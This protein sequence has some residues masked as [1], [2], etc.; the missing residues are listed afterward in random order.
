MH[1]SDCIERPSLGDVQRLL[2]RAVRRQPLPDGYEQVF[3]VP[4]GANLEERLVLYRDMYWNRQIGALLE[5]LPDTC[6]LV[7]LAAFTPMLVDALSA[8]PSVHPAME[9]L[10]A[11]ILPHIAQHGTLSGHALC[12]LRFEVAMLNALVA[13]TPERPLTEL[14][15]DADSLQRVRFAL[16]PGASVAEAPEGDTIRLVGRSGERAAWWT[17]QR[18]DALLLER[19][20]GGATLEV[21]CKAAASDGTTTAEQAMSHVATL[22]M[23]LLREHLLCEEG[24]SA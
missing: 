10:P 13:P 16:I 20:R 1:V 19:M 2:W 14:P 4:Q 23:M 6:E 7:G 24:A 3:C 5:L 17:I 12:V 21:L 11:R 9:Q 15:G 22:L 18:G 8:L